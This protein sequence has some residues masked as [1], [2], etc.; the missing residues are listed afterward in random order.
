MD[1]ERV[2]LKGHGILVGSMRYSCC[3]NMIDMTCSLNV[4][5]LRTP[6]AARKAVPSDL[7]G[8]RWQALD[9]DLVM[10]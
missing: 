1:G 7:L 8:S 3:D 5:S 4:S 6:S 9:R 10:W 2:L